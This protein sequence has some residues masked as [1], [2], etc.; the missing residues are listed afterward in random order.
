[1]YITPIFGKGAGKRCNHITAPPMKPIEFC[2][3]RLTSYIGL[4]IGF[5]DSFSLKG[6]PSGIPKQSAPPTRCA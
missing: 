4:A 5:L 1:M 3:V 6:D 2:L